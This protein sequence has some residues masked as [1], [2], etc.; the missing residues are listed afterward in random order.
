MKKVYIII[1]AALLTAC[2]DEP[3]IPDTPDDTT[4]TVGGPRA[5]VLCEGAWGCNDASLSSLFIGNGDIDNE[6][7]EVANGRGLG[8]VAQDIMIY[9]SKAYVTVTFSNSLE[10][11]DTATGRSVQ[12]SLA[13]H[14]RY[15]AAKGSH[16]YVSCYDGHQV[17]VFDTADL[18]HPES[19]LPLGNFQPEGLTVAAGKLFVASSWIQQQNQNYEY[20][21]LVYVFNLTTNTLDTMLAVGLNP[22]MVVAI[23]DNRVAVNYSG[24]YGAAAAGCAVIDANTLA[25]TKL[26]R[27]ATGMAASGG[28]LYGFSREGYSS[29]ATATYWRYDGTSFT[30]IPI[31]VNTPYSISADATG[32]IYVTTDGNYI[33]A[34]DVLCFTADGTL[35]WRNEAGI[36]P[37]KVVFLGE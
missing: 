10:V 14:P 35:R 4:S 18:D 36:L 27:S 32:N 19:I 6:W 15:L 22:Q 26:G 13:M 30:E 7:F 23:D 8:D 33:A 2:V 21:S 24:D 17:A 1:F 28:M 31:N 34:G 20:D 5:L 11:I 37:K 16:I 29:S 3:Y 12:H 25:V 9:G